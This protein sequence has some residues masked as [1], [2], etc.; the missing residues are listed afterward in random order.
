MEK[1]ASWSALTNSNP[2]MSLVNERYN[3]LEGEGVFNLSDISLV[4]CV[5]LLYEAFSEQIEAYSCWSA[6]CAHLFSLIVPQILVFIVLNIPVT[7]FLPVKMVGKH[8]INKYKKT[9]DQK[10]AQFSNILYW[11]APLFTK[12]TEESDSSRCDNLRGLWLEILI[13][14]LMNCLLQ[15]VLG[16]ICF[17]DMQNTK[18]KAHPDVGWR[19]LWYCLSLRFILRLILGCLHCTSL[20]RQ[21]VIVVF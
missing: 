7:L 14:L 10:L 19:H 6:W 11:V 21:F 4:R 20:E 3:Y 2:C 17:Y 12:Q 18:H 5:K 1:T 16:S 13:F 9:C 15:W 8:L